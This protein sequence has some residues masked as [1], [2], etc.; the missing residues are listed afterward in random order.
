MTRDY[1]P[2]RMS[3][4]ATKAN[5]TKRARWQAL[6]SNPEAERVM[7]AY[8]DLH[9]QW[10]HARA[11]SMPGCGCDA[12]RCP[13]WD[14]DAAHRAEHALQLQMDGLLARFPDWFGT[15]AG[16]MKRFKSSVF[17]RWCADR[18]A[19]NAAADP[20]FTP[21]DRAALDAWLRDAP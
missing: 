8:W 1:I 17:P 13:W 12:P 9:A 6:V 14:G 15:T 4:A 20:T 16:Y 21:A 5:A 11:H 19:Q 3:P 7:L 18:R 10:R 2:A